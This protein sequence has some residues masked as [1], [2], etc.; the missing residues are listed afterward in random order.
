M[1]AESRHIEEDRV[2][3]IDIALI[4]P[5]ICEHALHIVESVEV[6][7]IVLVVFAAKLLEHGEISSRHQSWLVVS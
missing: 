4:S 2:A 5:L 6:L 3:V 7:R 1:L